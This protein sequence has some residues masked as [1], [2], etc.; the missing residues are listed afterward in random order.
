MDPLIRTKLSY[1]GY[2]I[3][4]L[5]SCCPMVAKQVP[6]KGEE[7]RT[8]PLP[9]PA[10]LSATGVDRETYCLRR[11]G[12]PTSGKS[13]FLP[14]VSNPLLKPP[15]VAAVSTSGAGKSQSYL[16]LFSFPGECRFPELA[17]QKPALHCVQLCKPP[18]LFN[19][20]ILLVVSCPE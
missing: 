4:C 7:S 10:L 18:S 2:K 1:K 12:T 3:N 5:A 6:P 17:N 19:C 20:F 16:P 8:A 11:Q 13:L 14:D 15:L 9:P